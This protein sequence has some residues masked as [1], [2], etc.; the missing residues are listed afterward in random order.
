MSVIN[1]KKDAKIEVIPCGRAGIDLNTQSLNCPFKDNEAYK[2]TVGGSPANI[3]QGLAKLGV[4]TGFIGKVSGNGMGDYIKEVFETAG[5]DTQGLIF[6]KTGAL[7]CLAITEILAPSNSGSYL[8]RN[9]TADLLIDESEISEEYVKSAAAVVISGTALSS[10]PSREAMYKVVEYANKHNT[11]VVMDIDF[12]P[13][14]WK[15]P[16]ETAI[17]YEDMLK[18]CDIILGNREEFDAVEYLSMPG[19]KDNAR[20]AKVFL[21][22][23]ASIVIVKDG[24]KGSVAYTKEGKVIKCSIIRVNI[25]KTFGSGDAYAAGF[26]YGLFRGKDLYESMRIGSA[27]AAIT[28]TGMSCAEAMPNVEEV[29][30]FMKENSFEA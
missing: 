1:I 26:L 14:G 17:Y 13:Y 30:A 10:S 9:G 21:E 23:R 11:L 3:A 6:D 7:N 27:C 22:Q 24:E 15:S 2:K 5:I 8:Y 18:R 29:T 16:V 25:K 4:K 28:L 20:S 19:N 12:R